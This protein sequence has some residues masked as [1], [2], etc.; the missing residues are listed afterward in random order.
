[1]DQGYIEYTNIFYC[2]TLQNLPKFGFLKTNHLATLTYIIIVRSYHFL[3]RCLDDGSGG[4]EEFLGGPASADNRVTRVDGADSEDSSG[5]PD[6]S[7]SK[8]EKYTK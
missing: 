4:P 2:K 6:F 3:F 5:L 1:M 8:H 7:W